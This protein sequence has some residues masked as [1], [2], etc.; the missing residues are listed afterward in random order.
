VVGAGGVF[1]APEGYLTGAAEI[2]RRHDVLFVADEV[3]TG[4]GRLG[5]WFASIRFGIEPDLITCAKGITSGYVPLGA[6]VASPRVAEPFFRPGAPLWRH[7]YTYSGHA[8]AAAVGLANLDILEREQLLARS[9]EMEGELASALEPLAELPAVD[10]VRAGT[11]LVAAVT[12]SAEF[13]GQDP[14]WAGR[15]T[16]ALP[17]HGVLS[18]L[19]ADGSLQISPPLVSGPDDFAL[20]ADAISKA[21]EVEVAAPAS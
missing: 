13:R 4:F 21:V 15:V 12:L 3:I 20:L 14:L 17:E 10:E 11:G 6:V 1:V 16:G 7:G 9:R 8:T 19:L 2:C 18:R 5:D